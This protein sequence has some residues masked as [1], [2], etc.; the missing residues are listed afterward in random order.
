MSRASKLISLAAIAFAVMSCGGSEQAAQMA[1]VDGVIEGAPASEV[2]IGKLDVNQLVVLDTLTTDQDGKFQ[3]E[4]EVKKGN[5]EFVYVY[6]EGAKVASLL[7]EADDEVAVNVPVEGETLIE[8]SEES[9]KLMQV[10]LEHAAMSAL[11]A[12]YAAQLEDAS[13]SQ[14][15]KVVRQMTENYREYNRKSIKYVMQNCHSLTAIPVLY[16]TLGDLPLFAMST[17]AVMFSSIADSLATVYPE[18][19]FVKSLRADADA[20]M[21]ELELMRRIELAEEVGYLDIALPGLD[22]SVKKLSEVDS[23]VVLLYFWTSSRANQNNFNIEVLKKLYNDYHKKGFDIY[24]VS[25]DVDKVQWATTVMGQNLPWTNVCDI[26]G[27]ASEYAT[28]YN[29]QAL[30]AAFVISDG[31]LVDGELVDEASFRKLLDK[32]LK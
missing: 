19:K 29:L 10:E 27:A 5:P 17:D 31:E 16:R 12:D 28:L 22:G 32:L 8:G 15:D 11:F 4:L 25:L 23:K 6:Y 3:Y 9:A 30:P 14:Y 13:Q 20:R 18:S 21:A 7:L 26:R 2:V 24:Q 1:K